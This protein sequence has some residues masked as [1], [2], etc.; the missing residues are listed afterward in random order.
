MSKLKCQASAPT[1]E[2]GTP[3]TPSVTDGCRPI[4]EVGR[5]SVSLPKTLPSAITR[6]T[7]SLLPEQAVAHAGVR[8]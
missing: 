2:L 8:W 3:G 5:S 1:R 7:R 6:S 4:G